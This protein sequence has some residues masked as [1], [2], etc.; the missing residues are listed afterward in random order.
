M[1]GWVIYNTMDEHIAGIGETAPGFSV[2]TDSGVKIT[3]AS[4]GGRVLL[5]NFWATW[6]APCVQEVP[7][8]NELQ[9]QLAQSGVV[10]LGV[11]VDRNEKVYKNFLKRFNISFQ[12][13]RDP[14]E[15][16]SAKYGTYKFP[17]TYIIDKNGKILQKFIGPPEKGWT[18]PEIV[19]YVKSL[20]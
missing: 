8:L 10:V 4:F 12:T 5:L 9:K 2:T 11:S 13:M 17:E 1:L 15:D 14:A 16:I 3:P 19:N 20:L 18:D 7:S 6:C